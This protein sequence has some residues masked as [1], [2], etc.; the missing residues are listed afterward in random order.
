MDLKRTNDMST[1]EGG[2]NIV[3]DGLILYLD[4]ANPKSY[5]SGSTTWVDMSNG[6]NNGILTNG[7]TFNQ[8]NGGS[9]VFDGV[10]DRVSKVGAINTGQNF[11]VNA[12]I[13]PTLLG[14][15]RRAVIGNG[16]PYNSRQG[17][18]FCTAGG[19]I[20]NTFFFSIGGD[21]AY[22]VATANTLT[23]NTWQYITA[24]VTNGG[25]GIDLYRNGETTNTSLIVLNS[26]VI[27][28]SNLE[29]NIGF[30]HSTENDPF[31]GRIAQTSIYNKTLSQQEILQ[32]F[33]ATRSRFG[34]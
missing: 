20:N 8:L 15:T 17:W 11:T 22:R 21:V 10:N 14:T 33:N 3:T 12:W 5:V 29:F 23:P 24:V 32:N 9:I 16:Y 28:Y 26:G 4:G 31:T 19:N 25:G 6:G 30:R 13:F 18:L 1:V 2:G 34:I 27:T 7:P